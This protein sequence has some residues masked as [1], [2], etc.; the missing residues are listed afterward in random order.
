MLMLQAHVMMML[1]SDKVNHLSIYYSTSCCWR[2]TLN[3]STLRSVM[4]WQLSP[5]IELW[6][7]GLLIWNLLL[8]TFLKLLHHHQHLL[9]LRARICGLLDPS[10][11]LGAWRDTTTANLGRRS[12]ILNTWR[13][14]ERWIVHLSLLLSIGRVMRRLGRVRLL[15]EHALERRLW[16]GPTW[17]EESLMIFKWASFLSMLRH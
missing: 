8:A 4:M 15:I 7:G 1:S 17:F 14:G 12:F 11:L 16:G 3:C 2:L 9:L 6:R 13:L 10:W 5:E